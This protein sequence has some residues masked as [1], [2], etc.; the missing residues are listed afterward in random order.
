MSGSLRAFALFREERTS[1]WRP[2]AP[3]FTGQN[4]EARSDGQL[5][6]SEHEK[7]ITTST[8]RLDARQ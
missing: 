5:H 8:R 1:F 7:S 4:D 3:N 6:A 2:P